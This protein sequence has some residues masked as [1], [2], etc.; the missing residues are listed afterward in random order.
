MAQSAHWIS[1]PLTQQADGKENGA[2]MSCIAI[3]NAFAVVERFAAAD[4]LLGSASQLSLNEALQRL[5]ACP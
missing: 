5:R 2:G 3:P 1:A 4:L